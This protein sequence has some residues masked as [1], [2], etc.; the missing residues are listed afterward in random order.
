MVSG[1]ER[2]TASQNN[3][4]KVSPNG[5]DGQSGKFV[6]KKFEKATELRPTGFPQGQNTAIEQQITR[7]GNVVTTAN[8]AKTAATKP[9]PSPINFAALL[10]AAEPLD[11]EPREFRPISDGVDFGDGRDSRALPTSLSPINRQI[12]NVELIL[13]YKNDLVAATRMPGAPNSY[14]KMVNALL[15]ELM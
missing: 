3:I 10:G 9:A 5:G 6:A 13:K 7:G 11:S 2:P 4:M 8:A 12:E 15:R 14:K 1:G